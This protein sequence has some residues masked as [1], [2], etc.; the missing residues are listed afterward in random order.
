MIQVW[1]VHCYL[2][3]FPF[4]C[5]TSSAH[6]PFLHLSSAA[7]TQLPLSSHSAP[8]PLSCSNKAAAAPPFKLHSDWLQLK[9]F[10][11]AAEPLPQKV[12]KL[13]F[14]GIAFITSVNQGFIN[15]IA[16]FKLTLND[17]TQWN[18]NILFA[19]IRQVFELLGTRNSNYYLLGFEKSVIWII[20]YHLIII[21]LIWH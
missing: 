19:V 3:P 13:N 11:L 7:P 21:S 8:S 12:D 16:D 4:A 2:A 20:Y 5:C 17:L 10:Q 14:S 15:C 9:S 6:T 18:A 1:L